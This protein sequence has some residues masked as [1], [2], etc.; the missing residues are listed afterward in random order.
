MFLTSCLHIARFCVSSP[1]QS[2]L[3]QVHIYTVHPPLLRSS[4]P[5]PPLYIHLRQSFPHI[6]FIDSHNM[7]EPLSPYFLHLRGYLLSLLIISFLILSIFV[8]PQIYLNIL[9][10]A[11]SNFSPA[12]CRSYN[13]LVHL[14]LVPQPDF[15]STEPLT[16]SSNF[17]LITTPP[18]KCYQATSSEKLGMNS[19]NVPKVSRR[20]VRSILIGDVCLCKG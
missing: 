6:F 20:C 13:S 12:H 14:S 11:T 10:S 9:I 2:L 19:T 18:L 1:R 4:Y 3:P 16:P 5:S 17:R 7:S 15:S 8:T